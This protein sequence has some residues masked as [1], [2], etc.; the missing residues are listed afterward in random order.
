MNDGCGP[1]VLV[2]PPPSLGVAGVISQDVLLVGEGVFKIGWIRRGGG[3]GGGGGD[4]GGGVLRSTRGSAAA[5]APK[6][7]AKRSGLMFSISSALASLPP[8]IDECFAF[9]GVILE[10]PLSRRAA[11]VSQQ[12]RKGSDDCALPCVCL[13][14]SSNSRQKDK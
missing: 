13:L 7:R 6:M 5:S 8:R 9:V 10:V 4:G 14:L 12:L 1:A 11:R 3:G 2:P